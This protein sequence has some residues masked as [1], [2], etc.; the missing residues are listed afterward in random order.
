MTTE[1]DDGGGSSGTTAA[2]QRHNS[3]A[4]VHNSA[5]CGK[6]A[7]EDA[8]QTTMMHGDM[9]MTTTACDDTRGH[10]KRAWRDEDAQWH[11]DDSRRGATMTARCTMTTT[12][13][14]HSD[15]DQWPTPSKPPA[16]LPVPTAS[17]P[18]PSLSV[19]SRGTS[20]QT[21][22]LCSQPS[23]WEWGTI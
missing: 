13:T 3:A 19:K 22:D 12:T 10:S 7:R 9:T 11:S 15:N 8:A 1:G 6:M 4:T 18:V 14:A 23:P 2:R 16:S 21:L 20:R 17:G 5:G